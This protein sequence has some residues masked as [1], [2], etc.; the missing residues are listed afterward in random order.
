LDEIVLLLDLEELEGSTGAVAK[1]L[2]LL[3]I[4][5][6]EMAIEPAAAAF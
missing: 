2:R 5:I 4:V 3:D 1:L 6:V